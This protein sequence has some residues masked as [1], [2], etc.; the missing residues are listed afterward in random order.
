MVIKYLS[1]IKWPTIILSFFMLFFA[2]NELLYG[3]K[4]YFGIYFLGCVIAFS[5]IDISH[6]IYLKKEEEKLDQILRYVKF[7]HDIG[8]PVTLGK[9]PR[10]DGM[11]D[12]MKDE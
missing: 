7:K 5:A 6:G 1:Y 2:I 10:K 4:W 12:G 3:E 11:K 9:D 8:N